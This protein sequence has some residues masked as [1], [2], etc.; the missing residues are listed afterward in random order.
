ML[1]CGSRSEISKHKVAQANM[2][3]VVRFIWFF[4]VSFIAITKRSE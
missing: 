2:L 4:F 3:F 1:Y